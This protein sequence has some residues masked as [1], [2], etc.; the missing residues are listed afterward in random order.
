MI[1]TGAHPRSRS[2]R[3]ALG[4]LLAGALL[5]GA[6]LAGCGGG[7]SSKTTSSKP[8]TQPATTAAPATASALVARLQAPGHRPKAGGHWPI[9]VTLT[10]QGRPA[11]GHISYAFL[12]GG[13]VVSR[14]QVGGEPATFTGTF[15]DDI[16]WPSSAVGYPLTFR[17]IVTSPYGTRKLDYPVQV[18]R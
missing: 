10:W 6:P 13:Q 17:V 7:S 18:S 11:R 9:T 3:A 16:R 8:A 2:R 5:A 15:H 12:L 14:Q 1:A 4:A